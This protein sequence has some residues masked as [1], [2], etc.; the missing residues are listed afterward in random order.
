MHLARRPGDPACVI[1]EELL[2]AAEHPDELPAYVMRTSGSTGPAKYPVITRG[3]LRTVFGL[4]KD[5]LAPLV[6]PGARWTQVHSPIFG[7]SVFELLGPFTTG[8]SLVVLPSV[9]SLAHGLLHPDRRTG[10]VVVSLTPSELALVLDRAERGESRLPSHIV[11][12]G[13]SAHKAPLAR[14]FELA[15]A[16][17]PVVLNT[18]AAAETTG[19]VTTGQ[20]TRDS[21]PLVLAGDVGTPLPGVEVVIRRRDGTPIGPAPSGELGE[22]HV[23]GPTL[24]A[25]YFT[26]G[27]DDR[28]FTVRDGRREY[29]TGDLGAW[30]PGRRL[31]VLGRTGRTVKIGGKWLDLEEV[32][33]LVLASGIADEVCAVAGTYGEEQDRLLV[34][35][36]LPRDGG[37]GPETVRSR[38]VRALPWRMTVWLSIMQSLPRTDSGKVDTRSVGESTRTAALRRPITDRSVAGHVTRA[39]QELLGDGAGPDVNLFELGVD[40]LGVTHVASRL[41][42][43]LGRRITPAFL[44]DRPRI[45]LQIA[46]LEHW[47][48][49]TRGVRVPDPHNDSVARRRKTIR[50]GQRPRGEQQ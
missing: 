44:M 48:T 11:L 5:V 19:Q 50:A 10:P 21:V 23:A 30:G 35:V 36:V 14:L 41:S 9:E 15:G 6:P 38:L 18:Y 17:P 34:A 28:R 46:A 47:A 43:E 2:G 29:A 42:A 1:G 16:H 20:V 40:S 24:A 39:W 7:F 22:I 31:R 33:R 8:G 26:G 3:G 27:E 49:A 13:E 45:S 32:E 4:L 37:P 25:G 12:S